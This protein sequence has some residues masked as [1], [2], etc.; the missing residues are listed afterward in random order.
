MCHAIIEILCISLTFTQINKFIQAMNASKY[1]SQHV[2][3]Q[4]KVCTSKWPL[5]F[6]IDKM[7]SQYMDVCSHLQ[8]APKGRETW[9]LIEYKDAI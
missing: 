3:I 9:G 4:I 1:I 5:S 8:A 2:Y 7:Y 6:L